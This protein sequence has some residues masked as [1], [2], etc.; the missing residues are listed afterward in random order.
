LLEHIAASQ[1]IC[2]HEPSLKGAMLSYCVEAKGGAGRI[3]ATAPALGRGD[4]AP[5]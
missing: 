1:A 3:E 5:V 2:G 4:T